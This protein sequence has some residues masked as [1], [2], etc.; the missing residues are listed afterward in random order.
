[1]MMHG[2]TNFKPQTH[3]VVIWCSLKLSSHRYIR[4]A[5]Y[6]DLTRAPEANKKRSSLQTP[7]TTRPG[8]QN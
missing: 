2:L 3:I 8:S 5:I 7:E 4:S 6:K 1:M